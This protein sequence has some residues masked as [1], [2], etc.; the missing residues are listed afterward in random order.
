MALI[1]CPECTTE[2]SDTAMNCPKCAVQLRKPKRGFFGK[3]FK[4]L[5]IAF[6][7]LMAIWLFSYWG[8]VGEAVGTA[9]GDAAKAGTAIGATLGTGFIGS[10][11]A[12]GDIILGMFVLF[13]RPK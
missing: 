10:I 11:W 9:S 1:H 12:V 5:F 4:F 13:T 6:N 8:A 3:V 7:I 2:V